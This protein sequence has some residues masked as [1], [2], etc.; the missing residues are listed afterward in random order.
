M[1]DYRPMVSEFEPRWA[2]L[3]SVTAGPI[4]D[5]KLAIAHTTS[6]KTIEILL[7]FGATYQN[8]IPNDSREPQLSNSVHIIT[9]GPLWQKRGADKKRYIVS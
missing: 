4:S 6:I 7:N 2:Q 1:L 8:Y 3:F 5:V 9:I